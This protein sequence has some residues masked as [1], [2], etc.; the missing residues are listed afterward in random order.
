MKRYAV[1]LLLVLVSF[2][3]IAEAADKI[4]IGI[5]GFDSKAAGVSQEQAGII[6]DVLTR[7]LASSK[8]ISIYERQ[9][10]ARIGEEIKLSMSGLVDTHTAV[11]VGKIAGVQYVL[12][13]SVTELSQKASGAAIPFLGGLGVGGGNHQARAVIDVRLVETATSEIRLALSET[14]SSVN[15]TSAVT[16]SGIAFAETEFGGLEARA[17]TDAV[18]RLSYNIRSIIGGESSHV[19][20]A[21]GN[22]YVIDIGST[23]GAKEG[24]LYLVYA[25][26]RTLTNMNGEIIG[27]EKLPIAILKVRD[28]ASGHST[29]LLAPGCSG[30]LIERG[31]KIEP[32]A[33]GKGKNM[34]FITEKPRRSS[35]TF[36]EIFGAKPDAAGTVTTS[37]PQRADTNV[38]TV[39]ETDKSPV[40]AA[41]VAIKNQRSASKSGA[42]D[43]NTS[44]ETRVV[45]TYP[46][47]PGK[48]NLLGIQQRNAL[49]KYKGGRYRD[50]YTE[51]CAAAKE[52]EGN[53]L[54]AYWAGITADK[55]K[56]KDEAAKWLDTALKINPNYQPAIDY[57][58]KL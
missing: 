38:K 29:C 20:S 57:K 5:V 28:I 50:A 11:E 35:S 24:G 8:T 2:A 34:K 18:S 45:Q 46:I 31:D 47:D 23:M 32:I 12:M 58:A 41:P 51:F 40:A 25:D 14:G 22:E 15:N 17:I 39:P 26:G 3:G 43:P 6:T 13:G 1:V 54:A 44:T 48:A 33:V 4:R 36:E 9:Q 55:L 27:R 37:V 42:F 16:F 10:L 30:K 52:Y 19:I 21:G 7:E 53:Y 56:K 49:N